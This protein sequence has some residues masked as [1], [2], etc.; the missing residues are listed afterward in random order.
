MNLVM[1]SIVTLFAI[2]TATLSSRAQSVT[3]KFYICADDSAV[4]FLNGTQ[5]L[6]ANFQKGHKLTESSPTELKQGDHL[7]FQLNN[8]GGP[9][10]LLVQFVSLDAKT[11][12]HMPLAA[13]RML[14][15]PEATAFT[16]S[17]FRDAR[18]AKGIKHEL[19]PKL[20]PFKSRSQWV[21]GENETCAVALIITRELITPVTP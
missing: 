10:G 9:K 16:D 21:W 20:L 4:V 5:I 13:Y 19:G 2:L 12:I 3:G 1:K 8:K 18:S 6:A 15:N 17:E 14:N 7:V 11:I